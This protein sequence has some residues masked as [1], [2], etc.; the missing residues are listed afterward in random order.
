MTTTA[1]HRE[2]RHR[3][4]VSCCIDEAIVVPAHRGEPP[5]LTFVIDHDKV[6]ARSQRCG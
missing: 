2:A 6:V 3:T 1:I 5:R 4:A